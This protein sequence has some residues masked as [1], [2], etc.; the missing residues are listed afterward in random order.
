[1]PFNRNEAELEW[2]MH[3]PFVEHGEEF[4]CL[5]AIKS[6]YPLDFTMFVIREKGCAWHPMA[7]DAAAESGNL[8]LV[9]FCCENGCPKTKRACMIAAKNGFF[10]ILKYLRLEKACFWCAWTLYWAEKNDHA[11]CLEFARAYDCPDDF[12]YYNNNEKYSRKIVGRPIQNGVPYYRKFMRRRRQ[13]VNEDNED[14]EEEE[15]FNA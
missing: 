11:Q 4:F 15:Q 3:R 13:R 14:N 10:E 2:Q 1:M 12:A 8:T 5:R 9:C 7:L 6:L